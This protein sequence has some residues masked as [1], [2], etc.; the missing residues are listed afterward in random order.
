MTVCVRLGVHVGGV[1]MWSVGI[2]L[3]LR[4]YVCTGA[5]VRAYD[6]LNWSFKNVARANHKINLTIER[7]KEKVFYK[8]RECRNE[9]E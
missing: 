1:F 8:I 9:R 5:H 2:H 6:K 4:V 7:K 3:G